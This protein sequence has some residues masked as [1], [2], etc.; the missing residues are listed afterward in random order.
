MEIKM[1]NNSTTVPW[2]RERMDL[3]VTQTIREYANIAYTILEDEDGDPVCSMR[4]GGEQRM[5]ERVQK[6]IS[7]A[8]WK[9]SHE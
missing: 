5:W 8:G 9:I 3:H 7:D 1:G 2:P 6:A 4:D